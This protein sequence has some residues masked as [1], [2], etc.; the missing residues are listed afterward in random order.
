MTVRA[1]DA[2]TVVLVFPSPYGPGISLLDSLPILP[3]HKLKSA[4][5]AGTFQDTWGV[6]RYACRHHRPGAVCHPGIHTGAAPRLRAETA[7]LIHDAAG[8]ALRIWMRSSFNSRPTKN[9][10]VLRLEAGEVDLMTDRVR[11]EDLAALRDLERRAA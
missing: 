8:R 11:V 1:L 10:E 9:T 7:I 2:H 3:A 5:E 4:L 6:H